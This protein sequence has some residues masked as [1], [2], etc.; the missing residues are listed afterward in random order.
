M[1]IAVLSG[2]L[3]R[4]EITLSGRLVCAPGADV[5]FDSLFQQLRLFMLTLRVIQPTPIR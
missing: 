5:L 2:T 1:R 4:N 3:R